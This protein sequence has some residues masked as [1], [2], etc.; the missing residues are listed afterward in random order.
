MEAGQSTGAM[1]F[2]SR[3]PTS[4]EN[5]PLNQLQAF[6][7]ALSWYQFPRHGNLSLTNLHRREPA[8][9]LSAIIEQP[10][11]RSIISF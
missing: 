9:K 8:T 3:V 7:T 2:V 6:I 1:S 4:V 5:F 11:V 10:A